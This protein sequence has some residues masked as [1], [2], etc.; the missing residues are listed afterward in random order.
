MLVTLSTGVGGSLVSIGSAAGVVLIALVRNLYTFM[1]HLRWAW[2]IAIGYVASVM[3]H[4]RVNAAI[5]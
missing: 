5:L 1:N 3:T 2:A 4:L